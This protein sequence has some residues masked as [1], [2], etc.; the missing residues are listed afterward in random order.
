M[1]DGN[2]SLDGRKLSYKKFLR[3]A[4]FVADASS[5]G[6]YRLTLRY[7]SEVMRYTIILR[8]ED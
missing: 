5:N 4:R 2:W 3:L 6:T 1:P 7:E 8:R